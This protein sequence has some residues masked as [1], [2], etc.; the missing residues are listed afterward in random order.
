MSTQ[1]GVTWGSFYI[2][3]F[4]VVSVKG[5]V[6]HAVQPKLRLCTANEVFSMWC[7]W[8]A[9]VA[10]VIS[11]Y[12]LLKLMTSLSATALRKSCG[13]DSGHVTSPS[14][15]WTVKYSRQFLQAR[16]PSSAL[17]SKK[18]AKQKEKQQR[19]AARSL[20]E[21]FIPNWIFCQHP[22]HSH[23]DR[24][25]KYRV[26]FLIRLCFWSISSALSP[27]VENIRQKS[28]FL[29]VFTISN[30]TFSRDP[31]SCSVAF[32][33][34]PSSC[35]LFPDVMWTTCTHRKRRAEICDDSGSGKP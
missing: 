33:W 15:E 23:A 18:Q 7:L 8:L 14:C 13:G 12:S 25:I 3:I 4:S 11:S 16:V 32:I 2:Y 24:K 29:P 34:L 35:V 21:Q 30:S 9:V 26:K 17:V 6:S 27:H 19:A 1:C 5:V 28:N 22:T 31:H 10:G 20:K